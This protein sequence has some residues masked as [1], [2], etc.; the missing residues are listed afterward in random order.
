[1][2]RATLVVVVLL[3]ASLPNPAIAGARGE[4]IDHNLTVEHAFV[5]GDLW[6]EDHN[7]YLRETG[8][9][10]CQYP[11]EG[12]DE[13]V[14]ADDTGTIVA[15]NED[16]YRT[17]LVKDVVAHG[18]DASTFG[19]VDLFTTRSCYQGALVAV[20]DCSDG[21]QLAIF[22]QYASQDVF[23]HV[24]AVTSDY[25]VSY[26]LGHYCLVV[27]NQNDVRDHLHGDEYVPE[28]VR[29]TFPQSRTL[30]GLENSVWYDVAD[31]SDPT[32]GGFALTIDTA[33]ADYLLNV[34]I[35]LSG[36]Q[37]DIDGDGEWDY[38]SSCADTAACPGSLENPV[39]TFAYETRALHLFTIRTLWAG[40]ATDRAGN[41]LNVEPGMMWNE[42]TFDWETVEVRS[43]LDG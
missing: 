32:D 20:G 6:L 13:A 25:D 34:Q 4:D 38:T 2:K 3:L 1:M 10:N 31:G 14:I 43:S 35:W 26:R 41:V 9:I 17:P 18:G 24:T 15:Y 8:V 22:A 30:V 5:S 11:H 29:A 28:P 21:D 39:Y 23:R 42:H 7:A 19:D 12:W 36:I 27:V 37:I 40:V 33:G 16:Y